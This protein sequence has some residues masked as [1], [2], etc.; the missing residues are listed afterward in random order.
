MPVLKKKTIIII[1]ISACT[2]LIS[3]ILIWLFFPAILRGISPTLYTRYA[4]NETHKVISTELSGINDFFEFPELSDDDI[5]HLAV[6]LSDI[7][8]SINYG[9]FSSPHINLAKL[10]I[11]IDL[12]YDRAGKQASLDL[13]TGWD[14]SSFL[15][16]IFT[17]V[18][19]IALGV[20]DGTSWAVDAESIGRDLAKMGLPVDEDLELDLGFLFPDIISDEAKEKT[21]Q[22]VAD[23][24]KSLKFGRDR[25]TE[26]ITDSTAVVMTANIDGAE[27]QK[28]IGDMIESYFENSDRASE[29]Q[30]RFDHFN[31]VDF[32]LAVFIKDDHTI[33]AVRLSASADPASADPAFETVLTVQLAGEENMLDHIIVDVSIINNSISH[34]YTIESKGQHVPVDG[35]FTDTTIITGFDIGDVQLS[36]E[37]RK[38]ESLSFTI[39]A[40]PVVLDASGLLNANDELISLTL[41][42]LNIESVRHGSLNLYGDIGFSYGIAASEINDITAD[43]KNVAD[44]EIFKFLPLFMIVWEV[45]QQDQILMEMFGEPIY[46]LVVSFVLGDRLGSYITDYLDISGTGILDTLFDLFGGQLSDAFG[47]ILENLMLDNLSEILVNFG[48]FLNETVS[49]RLDDLFSGLFDFF[50]N[51]D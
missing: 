49:D 19:Q 17:N 8:A 41:H 29:L 45:L 15:L 13:R 12:L 24:F 5:K 1:A 42:N 16:T 11:G 44:I 36:S 2:V 46:D 38:D 37:I 25:N 35:V 47:S 33:Q 32:D 4:L 28:F 14:G 40:G 22:I 20:N 3:G 51:D 34:T 27:F 31:F 43:A 18:Q 9:G 50:Q 30:R 23:F 6:D 7:S 21:H 39:Q 10:D 26:H 48:D